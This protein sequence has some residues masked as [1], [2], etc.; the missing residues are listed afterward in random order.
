M[1][2]LSI[3]AIN[4]ILGPSSLHS[5]IYFISFSLNSLKYLIGTSSAYNN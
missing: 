1:K 3:K 2:G 5:S 4:W